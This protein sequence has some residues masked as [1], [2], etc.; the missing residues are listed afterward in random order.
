MKMKYIEDIDFYSN[1]SEEEL[2]E[3]RMNNPIRQ[4]RDEAMHAYEQIEA[5]D[6]DLICVNTVISCWLDYIHLTKGP[7]YVESHRK[8]ANIN[9]LEIYNIAVNGF[10]LSITED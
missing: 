7:Q 5:G 4:W 3:Q 2:R 10:N 1:Y 8:L 9:M 6:D